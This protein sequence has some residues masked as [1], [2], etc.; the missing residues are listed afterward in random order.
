MKFYSI[1]V[2]SLLQRMKIFYYAMLYTSNYIVIN[3]YNAVFA[4]LRICVFAYTYAYKIIT[5]SKKKKISYF[6]KNSMIKRSMKML[7]Y[8]IYLNKNP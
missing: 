3:L 2:K 4:Y 8:T 7:N 1:I 5:H 6:Q